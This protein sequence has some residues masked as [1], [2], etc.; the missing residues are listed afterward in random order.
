MQNIQLPT[1]L[2]TSCLQNNKIINSHPWWIS[3]FFPIAHTGGPVITNYHWCHCFACKLSKKNIKTSGLS[4]IQ[5]NLIPKYYCHYIT[6]VDFHLG[7]ITYFIVHI[8]SNYS[9]MF[10]EAI[11][12]QWSSYKTFCS[13]FCISTFSFCLFVF[14][15]ILFMVEI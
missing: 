8:I 2:V 13:F 1:I 10:W 15:M 4:R 6:S 7:A 12:H 3:F 14:R 5:L 11:N 9:A